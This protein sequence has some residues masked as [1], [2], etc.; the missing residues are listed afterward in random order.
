VL[1]VVG[2]GEVG[3][4]PRRQ[5]AGGDRGHGGG[6]GRAI[7]G[8][9]ARRRRDR[10]RPGRDHA[11]GVGDRGDGIVIATIAVVD[12][13]GG[14]RDG[15]ARAGV[16]GIVGLAQAGAR[17]R[18][19]KAR[20]GGRGRGAGRTIVRLGVGGRRDDQRGLVDGLGQYR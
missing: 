1:G 10:D 5:A 20:D 18:A 19:V 9:A 13:V 7:V 4:V 12:R 17:I 16:L 11:T 3:R 15:L 6:A 8:L 2:L 14:D